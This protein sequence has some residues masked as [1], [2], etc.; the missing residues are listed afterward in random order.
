M[1]RSRVRIFP[2]KYVGNAESRAADYVPVWL[3]V[4]VIGFEGI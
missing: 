4:K 2:C 3:K 1:F